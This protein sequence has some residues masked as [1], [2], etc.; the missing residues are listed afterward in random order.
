MLAALFKASRSFE[1]FF[2]Y[3]HF[4]SFVYFWFF[5]WDLLYFE[6]QLVTAAPAEGSISQKFDFQLVAQHSRAAARGTLFG[7]SCIFVIQLANESSLSANDVDILEA[8]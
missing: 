2:F 6:P 7:I 5:F 1:A 4:F 3:F 8:L